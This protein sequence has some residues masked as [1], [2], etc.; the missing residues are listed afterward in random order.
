MIKSHSP[1][2]VCVCVGCYKSATAI[3]QR[4]NVTFDVPFGVPAGAVLKVTA[5]RSV[6][7]LPKCLAHFLAFLTSYQ[8]VH[9]GITMPPSSLK[10]NIFHIGVEP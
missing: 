1:S 8:Y 6:T 7:L 5:K 4:E 9:P 2:C 3:Q 10:Q